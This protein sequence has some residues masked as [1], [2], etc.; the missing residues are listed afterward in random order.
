MGFTTCVCAVAE[1]GGDWGKAHTTTN[2]WVMGVIW[3]Y[4]NGWAGGLTGLAREEKKQFCF[5]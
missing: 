3:V 2:W 4:G 5:F 1:C